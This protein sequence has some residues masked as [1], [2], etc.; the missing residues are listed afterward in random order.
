MILVLWDIDRT[1]VYTG[2]ID[3]R[4]YLETFT[5]VVGCTPTAL[6]ARG[7]GTT[8]PLAVRELLRA[9]EVP[10]HS[11]ETLAARIVAELPQRLSDYRDVLASR[12]V[13]LPGAVAALDAVHQ[14]KHL[15]ATVV[16]GNLRGSAETKLSSLGL[17]GY[18]DT[19]IGGFASDDPHRPAL[20]RIAQDRAAAKHG[21][22]FDRTNT[23]IV[24]DSLKDVRTGL[25]GGAKVIGIASGTT[26]T[27]QLRAAG[28]QHVLPDLTDTA[29]L[30]HLI[31]Q[32]HAQTSVR[33]R[34]HRLSRNPDVLFCY[35]TLRFDAVLESLLGR[36]PRKKPA[37]APGYRAAA[38]QD[39][40]YPGL[41]SDEEGGSVTGVV[42]T[43]LTDK[44]WH[45]LEAFEDERYELREVQLSNRRRA[46]TYVWKGGD[47]QADQWDAAEFETQHLAAYAARCARLAPGLAAG[48]PKGE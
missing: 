38:L 22:H 16:T 23:V 25:E 24:G 45:I 33:P 37:S 42:L 44:E 4:V 9:N 21:G 27:E 35:G 46:W 34:Y 18:L 19:T 43:D 1:L 30:L 7:T 36:V 41:V 10:E 39:R 31:N 15:I 17:S 6:P 20:V 32:I 2:D 29:T 13:I 12:G 47:V 3:R 26:T 11:V 48:E 5:S 28:A 8:M 14:A 40:V